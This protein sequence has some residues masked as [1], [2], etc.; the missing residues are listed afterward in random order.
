MRFSV[1]SS[2]LEL[3]QQQKHSHTGRDHVPLLNSCSQRRD[4]MEFTALCIRLSLNVLFLL[5]APD[6]RVGSVFLHVVADRLQFFEY[7]TVT[8]R[9]E[10]LKGEELSCRSPAKI[11]PT[12]SSCSIQHAFPE[13]SGEYWCETGAVR[14]NSINITVTAGSVILESPVLPAAEG[15]DVALRCRNKTT[16][17][18]LTA[19][20][21]KDGVFIASGSAGNISIFNVSKSDEGLYRCS[22]SDAGD[23]QESRITVRETRP[24]PSSPS[25]SSPSPWIVVT[26]LFMV[27]L[28]VVGLLHFGKDYCQRGAETFH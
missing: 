22:I 5:C 16:S 7:E 21:Y 23:S 20:F 10:E 27:L 2:E 25:S 17:S 3:H 13:D 19:D 6:Q 8:F 28:L 12:G 9:C 15:D 1:S 11:D 18:D 14:S 26:S 24:P 4:D